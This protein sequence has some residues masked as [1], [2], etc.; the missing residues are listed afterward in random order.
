MLAREIYKTAWET[1]VR[2]KGLILMA[3]PRQVGKTTFA[4]M[5]LRRHTNGLYFNWDISSHRNRLVSDP[6]FFEEDVVRK[7]E[8]VPLVVF[9]ELHKYREWKNYLKGLSDRFGREYRFLV[10]GS[11]RLEMFQTAGDSLAGRYALFHMW[12]LTL[13]ELSPGRRDMGSFLSDP[14]LVERMAP[15]LRE[16]WMTIM[17]FSG[18]PEPFLAAGKDQW[19]RWSRTHSRQLVREDIRDLTA[20]RDL[21]SLQLLYESLLPPRVGSPLSVNELSRIMR[22]AH[23][24]VKQWLLVLEKFYL[25]F[26]I[27]PWHRRISRA[28]VKEP[29]FYYFNLPLVRDA[30]ARFEN[31]VALELLR[32]VNLW[33]DLGWGDFTLHYLRDRNKREVDF[34]IAQEDEPVLL[35]EAKLADRTPASALRRFQEQ[36]GVPAVQLV[37]EADPDEGFRLFSGGENR[38]LVVPAWQWL[39]QLP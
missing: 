21:E 9:D 23:N 35:V 14:L 39:A 27:R 32:A 2:D 5:L 30:A 11:G 1:L 12:P 17:E 18:F 24:T 16:R 31:A 15:E 8:S 3:G 26:R 33:N 34:L 10:T 29:K 6:F 4:R 28:V 19:R 7:D 13:T 20:I 22:V 25:I 36:L 38:I 37:H